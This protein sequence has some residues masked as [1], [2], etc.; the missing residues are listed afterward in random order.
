MVPGEC[1]KVIEGLTDLK[2]SKEEMKP[3][4]IPILEKCPTLTA[5]DVL[6]NLGIAR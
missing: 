5:E 4:M 3:L 2:L 1:D 6:S